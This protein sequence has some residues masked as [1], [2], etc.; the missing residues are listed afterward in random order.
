[1]QSP[2]IFNLMKKIMLLSLAFLLTQSGFIKSVSQVM[3]DKKQIAI[4]WQNFK[5][6][7]YIEVLNGKLGE[8]SQS[9]KEKVKS[10][11]IILPSDLVNL[12]AWKYPSLTLSL[13]M[14]VAQP[15]FPFTQEITPSPSS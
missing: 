4:E 2:V 1:M 3:T 8:R 5:P 15:S 11:R 10:A 6:S 7:G 12:T 9:A 14:A 13:I